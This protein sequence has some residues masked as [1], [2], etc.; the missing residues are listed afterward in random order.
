VALTAPVGCG[1]GKQVSD[2]EAARTAL[3]SFTKAFGTGDGKKACDLLTTAARA[4]F[5]KRVQALVPTRD[6]ATAIRKVHDAAG[7]EVNSALAAATV[8]SVKVSGNT[9]IAMLTASGHTTS[10]ALAKQ[11][12][13][14]KLTGFP[15][16]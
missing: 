7:A 11:G 3:T 1:G 9:A 8:S 13:S 12:G 15:G 10:V 4:A 6:C 14:W 5:L 2:P 16:I